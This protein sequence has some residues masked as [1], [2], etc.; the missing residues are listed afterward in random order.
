MSWEKEYEDL[1]LSLFVS[2]SKFKNTQKMCISIWED[3]YSS[4]RDTNII[5]SL[6]LERTLPIQ[7]LRSNSKLPFRRRLWRIHHSSFS[8]LH[9]AR[10]LLSQGSTNSET[11]F[12]RANTFCTSAHIIC[13]SLVWDLAYDSLPSPRLL[14][15]LLD[16]WKIWG[17]I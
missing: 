2:V 15:W 6:S 1:K 7:H 16:F 14:R 17:P 11:Q 10:Y 9:N 13:G 5:H 12:A 8:K 4:Y 3:L